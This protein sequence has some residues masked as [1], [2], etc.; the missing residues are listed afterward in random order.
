MMIHRTFDCDEKK[1]WLSSVETVP[2]VKFGEVFFYYIKRTSTFVEILKPRKKDFYVR[3]NAKYRVKGLPSVGMLLPRKRISTSRRNAKTGKRIS[4]P[5]GMLNT[6]KKDFYTR[7]NAKYQAKG[8]QQCD[9]SQFVYFEMRAQS[10]CFEQ[11][12]NGGEGQILP[13]LF[14]KSVCF[15][16]ADQF[17]PTLLVRL[18][19]CDDSE[20]PDAVFVLVLLKWSS[21]YKISSFHEL[22]W[23]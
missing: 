7:R 11:L 8:D 13:F 20:H 17:F 4:T 1:C 2:A 12:D 22:F 18:R 3:R 16:Y 14:W 10:H 5:V 23:L 19:F 6:G 9:F 21:P 15:L